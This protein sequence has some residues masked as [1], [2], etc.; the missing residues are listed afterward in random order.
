MFFFNTKNKLISKLKVVIL[1]L[2]EHFEV[3]VISYRTYMNWATRSPDLFYLEFFL[4]DYLNNRVNRNP[5]QTLHE[6]KLIISAKA[7]GIAGNLAANLK[8]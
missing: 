6:Q 8:C 4:W 5:Q 1:W 3:R 2:H 7:M